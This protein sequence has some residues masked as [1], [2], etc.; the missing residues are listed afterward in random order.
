[1][2]LCIYKRAATVE[3]SRSSMTHDARNFIDGYIHHHTYVNLHNKSRM[4]QLS[5]VCRQLDARN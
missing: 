2:Y 4:Q 5:P 3:D 1:M